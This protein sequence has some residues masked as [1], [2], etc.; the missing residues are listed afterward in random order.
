[1]EFGNTVLD[2]S[3]VTLRVG[4]RS[5]PI[6]HRE[7]QLMAFLMRNPR[8]YFSVDTLLDRVW[9][10]GADVEQGTVWAHISYL[11]K[12]LETLGADIRIQSKRGIGYALE[13][14]T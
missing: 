5:C 3:C 11:R 4:N 14:K 12:K 2:L 13:E 6:S 1:M 10:I 8:V 9:G 7:S